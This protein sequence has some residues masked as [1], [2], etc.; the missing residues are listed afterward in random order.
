MLWKELNTVDSPIFIVVV[1]NTSVS[2]HPF[3]SIKWTYKTQY[4]LKWAKI[5]V[6]YIYITAI[7]YKM[8]K[9]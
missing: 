5:F 1:K 6:K 7:P 2:R 8:G 4:I 9:F 3:Y